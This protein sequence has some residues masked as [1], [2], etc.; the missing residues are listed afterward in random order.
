VPGRFWLTGKGLALQ[1][2]AATKNPK[3]RARGYKSDEHGYLFYF[4]TTNLIVLEYDPA[5]SL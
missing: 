3:P 2:S 4:S 5:L 1:Q